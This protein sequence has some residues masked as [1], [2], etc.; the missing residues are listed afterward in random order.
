VVLLV[1]TLQGFSTTSLVNRAKAGNM[2]GNKAGN[3]AGNLAGKS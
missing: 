3:L 2:A 1:D